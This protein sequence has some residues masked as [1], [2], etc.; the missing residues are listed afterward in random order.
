M[1]FVRQ[2]GVLL[3]LGALPT[4]SES[5]F[6]SP[7]VQ[8]LGREIFGATASEPVALANAAGGGGIFLPTTSEGLLPMALKAVL[9]LDVAVADSR[10]PLRMTHRRIDGNDIY[11][12][13]ND[14]PRLWQGRVEFT[15]AGLVEQWNP[16]TG[17]ALSISQRKP[18]TLTL[19]PYG[20]TFVRCSEPPPS[21][22]LP[23]RSGSLPNLQFKPLPLAQPAMVRGQYVSAEL[24]RISSPDRSDAI[25]FEA[26]ATLTATGVDTFLFA[27]FH[28]ETP[29]NL[30]AADCLVMDTW[31]PEGQKT[32]N[33]MILILHQEEGGDF[34]AGSV[35]SLGS[36]GA[37]RS[38]VPLNQFQHAGWS[39][40][41]NGVLDLTRIT[42]VSI[43]WGGYL[44]HAGEQVWFMVSPPQ[45]GLIEHGP[46]T[47]K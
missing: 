40:D 6:P 5:E 41:L 27:R 9:Q 34:M 15:A 29:V 8:A 12:L 38:I 16:A 30:A 7:R 11:F 19:E 39:R 23:L 21:P 47:G 45:L 43:G 31:V 18:I 44:G 4:N 17:Q 2:G 10:A 14:S 37:E 32:H 35:R 36:S 1:R 26:K 20:A 13:I 46:T 25:R 42:G 22:R 28:F 24:V 3:A 33:E